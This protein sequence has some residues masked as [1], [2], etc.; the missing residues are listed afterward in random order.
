[1]DFYIWTL[2]QNDP[3]IPNNLKP[4]DGHLD[5]RLLGP[6]INT[7]FTDILGTPAYNRLTSVVRF[8]NDQ[9]TGDAG[10]V[11]R[12][13]NASH[14]VKLPSV[15]RKLFHAIAEAE[16]ATLKTNNFYCALQGHAARIKV[17]H[18]YTKLVEQAKHN[19]P[20]IRAMLASHGCL[21]TQGHRWAV[22]VRKYVAQVL[23]INPTGSK[24]SN[25]LQEANMIS[26]FTR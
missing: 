11:N 21:V 1:M 26:L 4:T 18:Q 25:L 8:Y 23:G 15:Y 9:S 16:E 17:Q 2:V 24:M 14:N 13:K 3:D 12:A 7:I 20:R 10:V 5:P 22:S 19:H 6:T